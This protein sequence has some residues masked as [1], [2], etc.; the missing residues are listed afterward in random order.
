M[1]LQELSHLY[2]RLLAD[3]N[4]KIPTLGWGIE[5]VCY[6]IRIDAD[7]RVTGAIPY[8]AGEGRDQRSF[9][10]LLVP[11]HANRTSAILPFFLCDNGCYLFGLDGSKGEKKFAASK[12]LHDRVLGDV[13]C[14]A[15]NAMRAFFARGPQPEVLVGDDADAIAKNFIVFEYA[16]ENR[17]IHEMP[18][19]VQRWNSYREATVRKDTV[20]GQCA[21]TGE[22]APIA[23]LY[24]QVTGFRGAQSAGASLVSFNCQAFES[25]GKTG[26]RNASISE[27]AA[28]K[29][30]EA[31][32]YLS[33]DDGH[34]VS[35]GDTLFICW[36]DQAS[37][38]PIG[39]ITALLGFKTGV[40]GS[41]AEDERTLS[42]VREALRSLALGMAPSSSSPSAKFY[43]VGIAPNAARLSVR[44]FKVESYGEMAGHLIRY[45]DDIEM[46]DVKPVSVK[47][48]LRQVA[49]L[50]DE[51]AIP[52]TLIHGCFDAMLG[53]SPFPKS[54]MASVLSRMRADHASR[55]RWDMGQRAALL[56]GCL[57]RQI[58]IKGNTGERE[59][60]VALDKQNMNQGYVLGRLFA[61]IEQAQGTALGGDVNATVRDKYIA[62]A[63]TTPARV[64]PRL[65]ANCQNHLS[66][67]EKVGKRGA[68]IGI[69][70]DLDEIVDKLDG[71]N[72]L[73][74]RTLGMDDQGAFF[75]G[76]YQQRQVRF[77][78]KEI[79]GGQAD[80]S[81]QE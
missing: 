71:G 34:R 23:R 26:T 19:I 20:E 12:E 66:K 31:L 78:R 61:V 45:L 42:Q 69:Q 6:R 41:A 67:I 22:R 44:Y 49:P 56:K 4:V 46:V 10:R 7:G 24:P 79:K 62:A 2:D 21:I 8:V 75:I 76:Y 48:L 37:S 47:R 50:G 60:S 18:E 9:V 38:R 27:L 3:P 39:S 81:A 68:A 25:Y 35:I 13:D 74:P 77:A 15:A 72:G 16:P 33:K 65:L 51:G 32:R 43:I 58:R 63:S 29:S 11:E 14:P 80:P 70:K 53:G 54:L 73:F 57:N 36:T 5:K 64:F 30:G 1:I 28:F 52:S 40:N 17:F 55:N 59:F